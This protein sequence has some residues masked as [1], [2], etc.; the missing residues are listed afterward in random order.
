MSA[1]AARR[2]GMPV[3][4]PPLTSGCWSRTFPGRTEQVHEARAFLASLLADSPVVED[5]VL[6][7]SELAANAVQHS[8]SGGP[9]GTFTVTVALARSGA[10]LVTVDDRGGPWLRRPDA[11]LDGGRGLLIVGELA[12]ATG[13]LG[14]ETGRTAWFR[15]SD[16]GRPDGLYPAR[17]GCQARH[18][19]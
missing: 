5:A 3:I 15:M 10:L 7:L 18:E 14:S 8:K 13:V 2:P 17:P 11:D 12:A 16:S 9:G 19:Q 4:S 1:P 6:C